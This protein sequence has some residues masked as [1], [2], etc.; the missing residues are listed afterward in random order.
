MLQ[1]LATE[2]LASGFAGMKFRSFYAALRQDR[3]TAINCALFGYPIQEGQ[4]G[5]RS[6]NCVRLLKASYE[7]QFAPLLHTLWNQKI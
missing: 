5:L 2:A 3:E 6:W 1:L 4:L 7:F